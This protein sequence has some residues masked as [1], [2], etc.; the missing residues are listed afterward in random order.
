MKRLLL[1]LL[2]MTGLVH[3]QTQPVVTNPTFYD[4]S[5]VQIPLQFGFPFYGRVFTNSWMHSNG[6]V[7]FLDPAVPVE[8]AG[9]NPGA[10]AYCCAGIQPSTTM[11]QFS[12]M[13]APLW[14]DLYPTTSSSFRTEGTT[15]Y[16]K[17]FWNN[18]PEIS[19]F[20][21]LNSF[22]LEIR[23]S[24][25]IGAT[26]SLL[27]AS[28]QQTWI[29]TIGNPALNEWNE[30]HFGV[31]VPNTLSSWSM[32]VTNPGDMCS[33]NPLYSTTCPG[34]TDA[35]CS[36]NP[37]YSPS[38]AGYAGA[39]Y[40]QQCSINSLFDPGCPGYA[41]AYLDYQCSVNPLYATTCSGYEQA[42]FDQQCSLNGLYSNQCPNY[43]QAYALA[44]VVPSS[45][46]SSNVTTAS[47]PSVQISSDGTVSTTVS[48]TGN[49]TVDSVIK[50]ETTSATSP[51]ATVQ[52]AP[53]PNQEART[54]ATVQSDSKKE[55]K[56]A[57][58]SSSSGES[59]TKK[60][61]D[62]KSAKAETRKQAVA[63]AGQKASEEMDSAQSMQQQVQVQGVVIAAMGYTPGFDA[64]NIILPDGVGYKPFQVYKNQ[65]NVDNNRMLKGLSGAS[66]RLHSEL[67]D[68]QYQ[69][70]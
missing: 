29:G 67:T 55:T 33:I 41:A 2:F 17:Y 59:N 34:Y 15:E 54:N 23:P 30:I 11:P 53:A 13:I 40:S 8:G 20:G 45:S 9:Y 5:Y 32:A 52:L 44:Y 25:Y 18:I 47:E 50:T 69:N 14:T 12:Y 51:T 16:Q 19:N 49:S 70:R 42:Y 22:S 64:Y 6:V 43:A 1:A 35:M 63:K 66:D 37:L 36:S 46:T 39:Y 3:A 62:T 10:W 31:G 68:L 4:D 28:N 27:N 48:T 57:D 61:T 58:A 24:G 65:S 26:Y 7:S 38:C 21:A 60:Q 56:Q